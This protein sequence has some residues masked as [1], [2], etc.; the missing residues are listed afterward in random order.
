MREP[1]QSETKQSG[2]DKKQVVGPVE[3][4]LLCAICSSTSSSRHIT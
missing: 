1:R 4:G 2:Y 3:E